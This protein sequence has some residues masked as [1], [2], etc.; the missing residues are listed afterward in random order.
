VK[1][2]LLSNRS[3]AKQDQG[4]GGCCVQGDVERVWDDAVALGQKGACPPEHSPIARCPIRFRPDQVG[5]PPRAQLTGEQ[6]PVTDPEPIPQPRGMTG[7]GKSDAC[8]EP[9]R[10]GNRLDQRYPDQPAT[11]IVGLY[12]RDIGQIAKLHPVVGPENG[13]L[14]RL[15]DDKSV[16]HGASLT[17]RVPFVKQIKVF[18]FFFSKKNCFFLLCQEDLISLPR[19]TN[20]W[21]IQFTRLRNNFI[22]RRID[23]ATHAG[24]VEMNLC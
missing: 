4:G 21:Q 5:P 20:K 23:D 13:D 8:N 3:Y 10:E 18:W 11:R 17:S 14:E 16:E 15:Q 12:R 6:E 22:H 9:N 7:F 24:R 1:S 2:V 19:S